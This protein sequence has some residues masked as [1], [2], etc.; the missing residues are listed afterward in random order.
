MKT[1]QV[2]CSLTY[3]HCQSSEHQ[4]F[5]FQSFLLNSPS[6]NRISSPLFLK[7]CIR[8]RWARGGGIL[9]SADVIQY[10]HVFPMGQAGH[11]RPHVGRV[12]T[13]L[14]ASQVAFKLYRSVRGIVEP[15]MWHD[16]HMELI[17]VMGSNTCWN[18]SVV[19]YRLLHC[20]G[21]FGV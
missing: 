14:H 19:Q 6:P 16:Q 8:N 20:G 12:S 7:A 21:D 2:A 10:P 4:H 18:A 9:N 5:L 3:Y 11:Q 15:V 1:H 13:Q 17:C